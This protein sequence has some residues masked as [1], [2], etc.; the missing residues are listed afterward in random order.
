MS[1]AALVVVDLQN[2]FCE[3]VPGVAEQTGK[4]VAAARKAGVEVIFVRFLGDERYQGPSWRARNR[5][6]GKRTRC[7][8]DTAGARFHSV[9]PAPGERVFTKY[10]KFDAF[11]AAG[12]GEYL[13]TLGVHT[14]VLAGLFSDVCVD[15]TARTAFQRGYHITVPADCTT[16]LHLDPGAVLRF[17]AVLYGA[18]ITTGEE[19]ARTGGWAH[20]EE[21][22]HDAGVSR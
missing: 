15:T 14:L 1:G 4:T 6:L 11:L 19:L 8:E 20:R 3:G 7:R 17:M 18:R 2:D 12:F 21:Q 9:R 16:S 13:A 10:A 5:L 22:D